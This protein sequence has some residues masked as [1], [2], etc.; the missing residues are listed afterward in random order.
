MSAPLYGD[1]VADH[2][3]N[4]RNRGA[5]ESPDLVREGANPLC[6]DRVRIE[7][8]IAG[9]RIEAVRFQAEACMVTI[10]AASMLSGMLSGAP[11]SRARSMADAEL[12]GALKTELRPAR[13]GCAL[14]PLQ[15]VREALK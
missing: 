6:G 9:E 7:L 12:L 8:R 13:V 1:V 15:V 11:L 3:R 5:L 2:A 14:L 4:P 10:A